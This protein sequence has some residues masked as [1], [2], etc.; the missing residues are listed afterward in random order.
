LNQCKV[1]LNTAKFETPVSDEEL[2]ISIYGTPVLVVYIQELEMR[3]V[4]RGISVP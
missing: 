2:N 1:W 4:E 3:F